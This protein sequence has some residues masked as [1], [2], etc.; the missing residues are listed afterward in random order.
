MGCLVKIV[1]LNFSSSSKNKWLIR[2]K[3]EKNCMEKKKLL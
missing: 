3:V 2:Y 1:K